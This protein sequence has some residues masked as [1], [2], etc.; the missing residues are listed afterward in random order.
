MCLSPE[1]EEVKFSLWLTLLA[2]VEAD[3]SQRV[4]GGCKIRHFIAATSLLLHSAP[5]KVLVLFLMWRREWE[6]Q[7]PEMYK[8]II[9]CLEVLEKCPRPQTQV[10]LSIYKWAGAESVRSLWASTAQAG[11][12][13]LQRAAR[14]LWAV[15]W[16]SPSS[17]QPGELQISDQQREGEGWLSHSPALERSKDSLSYTWDLPHQ[18]MQDL[19]FRSIRSFPLPLSC[20]RQPQPHLCS[21]SLS[22]WL[23]AV[24]IIP[25]SSFF[26]EP[27]ANRR[28]P[29]PI[30]LLKTFH[31]WRHLDLTAFKTFSTILTE[32]AC[33]FLYLVPT[34]HLSVTHVQFRFDNTRLSNIKYRFGYSNHMKKSLTKTAL[35]CLP[36]HIQCGDFAQN[37]SRQLQSFSLSLCWYCPECVGLTMQQIRK[38]WMS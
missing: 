30:L 18:C 9:T 1:A 27:F 37:V 8:T 19:P 36:A 14:A 25:S 23:A 2:S 29:V 17:C 6:V 35:T 7:A 4:V 38:M 26:P 31:N 12:E 13:F 15:K 33:A 3:Q 24:L 10:P 20:P 11:C 34:H 28:T 21:S 16:I 32:A 5:L 22:F